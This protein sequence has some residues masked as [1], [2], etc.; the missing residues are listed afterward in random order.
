MFLEIAETCQHFAAQS[1]A[2][3]ACPRFSSGCI[4]LNLDLLLRS[5]VH[6]SFQTKKKGTPFDVP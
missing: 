6:H 2:R 3:C 1:H 4:D 5:Q